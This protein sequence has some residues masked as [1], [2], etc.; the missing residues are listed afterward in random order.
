MKKCPLL[1][2]FSEI[3]VFVSAVAGIPCEK[4]PSAGG[5][6][7]DKCALYDQERWCCG[8]MAVRKNE[9]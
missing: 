9:Q 7:D 6:L 2:V 3:V 1:F 8:L 5:C 4:K